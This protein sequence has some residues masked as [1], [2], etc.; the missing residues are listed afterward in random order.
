MVLFRHH[1]CLQ[2]FF[3]SPFAEDEFIYNI[4]YIGIPF[5][6]RALMILL[7]DYWISPALY[8]LIQLP[9]YSLNYAI[10]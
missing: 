10:F 3:F 7:K 4:T 2:K 6:W 1:L 5:I 8:E 9:L